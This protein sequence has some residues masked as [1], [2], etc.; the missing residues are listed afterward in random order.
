M[1]I[2]VGMMNIFLMT[3]L[4]GPS[5]AIACKSLPMTLVSYVGVLAT[6]GYFRLYLFSQLVASVF[7]EAPADWNTRACF[8][9]LLSSLLLLHVYWYTMFLVMLHRYVTKGRI[10]DVSE[11]KQAYPQG[12][13]FVAPTVKL[14]TKLKSS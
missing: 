13:H 10:K 12:H 2:T 14:T 8:G 5:G 11:D 7:Y 1:P 6:W 9:A 4:H 3:L